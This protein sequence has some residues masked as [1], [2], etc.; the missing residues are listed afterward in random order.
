MNKPGEILNVVEGA[1][2]K[3]IQIATEMTKEGVEQISNEG[4]A[5]LLEGT[6]I[7]FAAQGQTMLEKVDTAGLSPEEVAAVKNE[8][9]VE[10]DLNSTNQELNTSIGSSK[11]QIENFAD[12]MATF[13][14]NSAVPQAEKPAEAKVETAAETTAPVPV[15]EK[16]KFDMGIE[17]VEKKQ[18]R[19]EMLYDSINLGIKKRFAKIA[20][21]FF[22]ADDKIQRAGGIVVE[23]L[24]EE[25]EILK[26]IAQPV[27][28]QGV[29]MATNLA[30]YSA[31]KTQEFKGF[32]AR[33]GEQ[34]KKYVEKEIALQK[35]IEAANKEANAAM[36]KDLKDGMSSL[37]NGLKN[38]SKGCLDSYRNAQREAKRKYDVEMNTRKMDVYMKKM[39]SNAEK[40]KAHMEKAKKMEAKVRQLNALNIMLV[41]PQAA[42]PEAQ[43]EVVA[44]VAEATPVDAPAPIENTAPAAEPVATEATPVE[45]SVEN[46]VTTDTPETAIENPIAAEPVATA[47]AVPEM[48]TV[49]EQNPNVANLEGVM[50]ELDYVKNMENELI[51]SKSTMSPEIYKSEYERIDEF[52]QE[53]INK[54]L[55]QLRAKQNTVFLQKVRD[56]IGIDQFKRIEADFYKASDELKKK[57]ERIDKN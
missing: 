7:S 29:E 3:P 54:G 24:Q 9:G 33:K 8:T 46:T 25:V 52:K 42:A 23:K 5:K 53:I 34:I 32:L 41:A 16:Q 39:Y 48:K 50:G 1:V 4:L 49:V 20:D 11:S 13:G 22:A 31:L 17:N 19:G 21:G 26:F 35:A 38:F 45:A 36:I 40:S 15:V 37:Y 27:V 14:Q 56:E 55:A 51:E 30:N 47:E 28:A 43:Q 12:D 2:E 6:G 10:T 57:I 18:T 44:P